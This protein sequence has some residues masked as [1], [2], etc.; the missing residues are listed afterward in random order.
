[1]AKT[2]SG[3]YSE[4]VIDENWATSFYLVPPGK[5][6]KRDDLYKYPT[7]DPARCYDVKLPDGTEFMGCEINVQT[8][9]TRGMGGM[10]EDSSSSEAFFTT[11][12]LEIKLK[13]GFLLRYNESATNQKRRQLESQERERTQQDLLSRRSEID[14]KLKNL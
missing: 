9:H 6:V 11:N 13:S 10:S 2:S 3:V 7:L 14:R 4:L 12:N 5:K 8:H 1:M